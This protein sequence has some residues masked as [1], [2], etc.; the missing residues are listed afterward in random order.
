MK[1]MKLT[2]KQLAEQEKQAAITQLLEILKPGATVYT[3]LKRVS[4]S[5]MSRVISLK[6]VQDGEII[7]LDYLASLAIGY[8]MDNNGGLKVT[9]CGMDMGFHLVYV[10]GSALWPHGTPEPHGSRNGAP[11]TCGGYALKHR[12]I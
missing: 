6:A 7:T 11:D 4:K 3:E 2:K 12:W 8:R 5:G 9:G 10:L 1:E